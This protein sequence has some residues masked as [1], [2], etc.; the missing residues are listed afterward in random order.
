MS[1]LPDLPSET[2]SKADEGLR[3]ADAA[4]L[5]FYKSQIEDII[6]QLRDGQ[7]SP[8]HISDLIAF[9]LNR[10]LSKEATVFKPR[11]TQIMSPHAR[12]G[13]IAEAIQEKGFTEQE[14]A[15]LLEA[16]NGSLANI[17]QQI[18][19]VMPNDGN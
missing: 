9:L 1:G 11:T 12:Q 8:E 7:I 3:L 6:D 10:D 14:A 19:E 2:F 18:A 5:R 16:V 4:G 13:I 15:G 17:K